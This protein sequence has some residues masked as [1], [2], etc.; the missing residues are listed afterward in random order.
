MTHE[1]ALTVTARSTQQLAVAA[2]G[3]W[4]VEKAAVLERELAALPV[5]GVREAVFDISAISRLDT[6]GAWLLVRAVR[7]LRAQ[8]VAVRLTGVSPHFATLLKSV[9]RSYRPGRTA[10]PRR[11][12]VLQTV[13]SVGA[14]TLQAL[15]TAGDLVAFLGSVC[16]VFLRTLLRPARLRLTSTLFHMEQVGLN[17]VPIVSLLSFLIG[18]V[19]AYQGALQLRQFGAEIFTVDLVSISVL[20]ELGILLTAIIVAGRSGSAFTAQIGSMN[21]REEIDAMRTIGLD[22]LEVLVLPRV[23]A[24]VVTLPLLAFLADMM[25]LLG[26]GIMCWVA[27]DIPPEAFLARLNDTVGLWTFWVG[28]VKAP[29]FGALVAIVGCF[30]GLQVSGSA[31]SVGR[32]TTRSVVEAIFLVIIADAMFS[33]F[34]GVIGI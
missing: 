27:L 16:V 26:G 1:A 2:D 7:S 9:S 31:E 18:I 24:L 14:N 6:A 22:P 11:S 5:E 10:P 30:E 20:R 34:F 25:G 4:T 15:V 33:V 13:E 19:L 32:R 21:V 28:I 3:L 8:G 23:F 17:A 12:V 29:V